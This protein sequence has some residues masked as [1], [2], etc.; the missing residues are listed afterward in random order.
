MRYLKISGIIFLS[1]LLLSF[2]AGFVIVRFYQNEVKT[3]V[4]EQVNKNL[5]TK[6]IVNS[7]DIHFSVFHDFP[8][9]SVEFNNVKALDAW[10]AKVKDTL[11]KAQNISLEFNLMDVFYKKYAVEK[12]SISGVQ[13][14][15]RIN[16]KGE[17]NYH[18]WKSTSDS[19]SN[20]SK[21]NFSFALNK[22]TIQNAEVKYINQFNHSDCEF[23]LK[24][25]SLKG[26]FNSDEYDLETTTSALI[27][28]LTFG[29]ESYLKGENAAIKLSLYVNNKNNFYRIKEGEIKLE[30]VTLD[31]SGSLINTKTEGVADFKIDG[32]NMDIQSAMLL[33]PSK[34]KKYMNRYNSSGNI[35]FNGTVKGPIGHGVWPDLVATFGITKGEVSLDKSSMKLKNIDLK[36]SY[37]SKQGKTPQKTTLSIHNVTAE[38]NG[39][40]INGSFSI[41][42]FNDPVYSFNA[43]VNMGLDAIH[44]FIQMDTIESMSGN[45]KASIVYKGKLKNSENYYSDVTDATKASGE[46]VVSNASI[47][48]KNNTLRFDNINGNFSVNDD[49]LLVNDFSGNVSGSDFDLKG[50]LKNIFPFLFEKNQTVT[51][52]ATLHSTFLNLNEFL[53]NKNETSKKDTTAYNLHFSKNIAFT[54]NTNVQHLVFRKV[55]ATNVHGILRLKNQQLTADSVSLNAMDGSIT[56][57][58][59]IIDASQNDKVLTSCNAVLTNLN[60]TKMFYEM[61]NFGQDVLKDDNLKGT[62]TADIQFVAEWTHALKVLPNSIYVHSNITIEDGELIDFKPMESMSKFIRLSELKDVKF[63]TLKNQ[64]EIKDEQIIIP[65]MDINSSALNVTASGTHTFENKIDYKAKILLHDLL[66]QKFRKNRKPTDT[67]TK[68]E[69]DV[70]GKTTLF[71]SMTGTVEHPIVK[72]DTKDALIKVKQDLK[73]EK[74]NLKLVLKKEFGLFKKDTTLTDA[75]KPTKKPVFKVKWDPNKKAS[76][77]DTSQTNDGDY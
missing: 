14:N 20:T 19:I 62:A 48:L 30:H 66:A 43:N 15:I 32:K 50:I 24:N 68:D 61:G 49:D 33:L 12:L 42:N 3:L 10:D 71:I 63:S 53:E 2:I 16:E 31:L 72:Y 17:D 18:F 41:H 67:N 22:I 77:A 58:D 4:V 25:L 45:V 47:R 74:T 44:Q 13:L 36:G 39:G 54:L 52:D 60:I 40:T 1:I 34:A 6:V 57:S 26:K 27:H 11:F 38:L 29:S 76:P 75:E 23:L 46:V 37:S 73:A 5:N 7:N 65:Q 70:K 55:D 64:I 69:S 8:Y 51:A 56:L 9:A 35:Y 59:G 21:N 28:T